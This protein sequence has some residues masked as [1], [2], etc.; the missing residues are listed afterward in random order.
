MKAPSDDLHVAKKRG[1]ARLV[2]GNRGRKA[3]VESIESLSARQSSIRRDALKRVERAR[4]NLETVFQPIVD[5]RQGH[6][7]GAEA[8]SRFGGECRTDEAFSE[9]AAIGMG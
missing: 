6:A 1:L 2:P 3:P 5:L 8:L 4:I 7:V 9:A